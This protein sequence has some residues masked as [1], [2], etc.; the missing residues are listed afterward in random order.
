M[1]AKLEET[2]SITMSLR[3]VEI[4]A[5]ALEDQL[6]SSMKRIVFPNM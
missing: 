4:V 2:L 6:R 5:K 1:K 3:E